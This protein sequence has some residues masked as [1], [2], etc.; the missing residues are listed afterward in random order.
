MAQQAQHELY[1]GKSIERTEHPHIVKV[2]RVASGEPI[3]LG[4]RIMV[5]TIL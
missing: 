3:I 5:R 1:F 4:T 2:Q